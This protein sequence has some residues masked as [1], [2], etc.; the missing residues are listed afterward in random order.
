MSISVCMSNLD[1]YVVEVYIWIKSISFISIESNRDSRNSTKFLQTTFKIT[2]I[3]T[4][5][6]R[7]I[8]NAHNSPTSVQIG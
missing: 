8:S 3:N 1:Y 5:V 7:T 6:C 2:K 4:V